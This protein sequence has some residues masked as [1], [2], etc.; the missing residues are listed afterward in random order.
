MNEFDYV[1]VGAGAAG[2][3]LAN[4]L[5]AGGASV[6]LLEAGS[7]E[8]PAGVDDPAGWLGLHGSTADWGY[9][10][11]PQPGLLGR[12]T[13]EPRGRGL[14]GTG[15]LYAMMHVRGHPSDFDHWAYQGAAGWSYQDV[16]PYFDEL[17]P[18]AT[19]AGDSGN[20]ASRAF[21][22]ACRELGYKEI[23]DFNTSELAG[24]GWHHLDVKDGKRY[25]ARAAYLQPVLDRPNLTVRT[26]AHAT[27]LLISKHEC[28]GVE[29]RWQAEVARAYA[30]A[31]V[32]LAAGAIESP[33]LLMLSGIGHPSELAEFDIPVTAPLPG[34]GK[35]FHNHVLTGVMTEA[36]AQVPPPAHNFS[37]SA[38]FAT[39]QPGL[40]SPDIQLAF[41][42]APFYPAVKPNRSVSVL[43]G[44][45]R[46]MSRGWV[47]LGTADPFGKPLVHP[48]YLGD[49]ADVERLVY[50][51]RLA[52]A[53]VATRSFSEWNTQEVVP[54][55]DV[56][57]DQPLVDFV[58]ENA[59][60][61]HHHAGSCRMG[62]DDM[63]VVD[64]YLQVHGVVG[65]RVAD[66]SVMP[67][68]PSCNPHATV[69]MVAARAAD[70]I[71][72]VG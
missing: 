6:L 10:S 61:Y 50:A 49:R 51:V 53:L 44:V 45:V 65:L 54:G 40:P 39:T 62:I 1:V 5:S 38:L 14:G 19:H 12:S 35:N 70:L 60:S 63:S 33:K 48:N 24:A 41:V 46:P 32:V 64:P 22:E 42:H 56:Y 58:R 13:V 69:Q 43:P 57:G 26:N 4:R 34:V 9:R 8:L 66:A 3:V 28:T 31:E 20:P 11:V 30:R 17:E 2:S 27:R 18:P 68:L 25:G 15:N 59:D 52:R 67:A 7:A 23:D 21:I 29:Y 72:A 47:R 37:E 16:L 55:A 71:K 36:S